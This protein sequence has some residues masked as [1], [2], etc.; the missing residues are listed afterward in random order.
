VIDRIMPTRKDVPLLAH[1]REVDIN[2]TELMMG[3]DDGFL[4]VVIANRLPLAG[5]APD[6]S[7][8][9][10]TYHACLVSLENQFDRL[11]PE[12]PPHT[13]G[14]DFL[15]VA[16]DVYAVS[17]AV[18]DQVV[19]EQEVDAVVNPAWVGGSSVPM[20]RLWTAHGRRQGIPRHTRQWCRSTAGRP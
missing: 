17:P 18:Y 2:D 10:V 6:G 8:V 19:M 7:E 15:V 4:A 5:R 11:I 20:T 1:A 9:P 13:L 16:K 3:D 14:S 12:S